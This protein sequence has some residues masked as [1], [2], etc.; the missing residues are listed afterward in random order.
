VVLDK[1]LMLGGKAIDVTI[2][3]ISASPPLRSIT[4]C[5][6]SSFFLFLNGSNTIKS[7]FTIRVLQIGSACSSGMM[8]TKWSPPINTTNTPPLIPFAR[9][10]HYRGKCANDLIA[11]GKNIRIVAMLEIDSAD[12]AV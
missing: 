4:T 3:E 12:V 2:K 6:H 5:V 1:G 8:K 7:K 10:R 11:M 9:V